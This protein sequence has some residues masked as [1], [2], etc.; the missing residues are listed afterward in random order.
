[1]RF[2]RLASALRACNASNKHTAVLDAHVMGWNAI[3]LVSW[4]A[5]SC[6]AVKLP[7]VPRTNDVITAELAFTKRPS[8]VIADA[9]NCAELAVTVSQGNLRTS[10]DHLLHRSPA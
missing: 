1:M 3:V 8:N 6:S 2:V 7:V 10:E 5:L 9:R 4:L